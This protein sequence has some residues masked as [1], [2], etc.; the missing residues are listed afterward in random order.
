MRVVLDTVVFLR[1]LINPHGRWGR[2][3]FGLSDRYTI[4]LSPDIIRGV[5]SV[6]YRPGLRRR[7]PQMAESAPLEKVLAILERAEVVE[8][9]ERL[10]LCRDPNDDKFFECAVAGRAQYIVSEDNDILA[11][12]EFEGIKTVTGDELIA[13][14][15]AD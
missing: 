11:V 6:L 14:L 15:S 5:I 9:T 8:P 2:L 1:A 4:V 10:S 7:F 13:L 3:L 12:G